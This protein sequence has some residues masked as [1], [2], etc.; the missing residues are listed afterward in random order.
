MLTLLNYTVK[1][2]GLPFN[3]T[4]PAGNSND[5]SIHFLMKMCSPNN[6]HTCTCAYYWFSFMDTHI[7]MWTKA[8]IWSNFFQNLWLWGWWWPRNKVRRNWISPF[9]YLNQDFFFNL[10]FLPTPIC[11]FVGHF[12]Q[13]KFHVGQQFSRLYLEQSWQ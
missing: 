3:A 9:K 7:L 6:S 4:T 12:N 5:Y 13:R 2:N 1:R 8:N 10:F 11:W